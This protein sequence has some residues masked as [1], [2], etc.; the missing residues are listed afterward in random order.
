MPFEYELALDKS[1]FEFDVSVS[2]ADNVYFFEVSIGAVLAIDD[3]SCVLT[4]LMMPNAEILYDRLAEMK[5]IEPRFLDYT[6]LLNANKP[7]G[8]RNLVYAYPVMFKDVDHI[9]IQIMYANF[10]LIWTVLHEVA[11]V[12]LGHFQLLDEESRKFSDKIHKNLILRNFECDF[13]IDQEKINLCMELCADTYATSKFFST[14][15]RS[16]AIRFSLPKMVRS[17]LSALSFLMYSS[18]IYCLLL[19]RRQSSFSTYGRQFVGQY[20]APRIRMF[21]IMA[22][23]VPSIDNNKKI[24]APFYDVLGEPDNT[25]TL[26]TEEFWKVFSGCLGYFDK[27]LIAVQ[28]VPILP[29]ELDF[30][31]DL[32]SSAPA[33]LRYRQVRDELYYKSLSQIAAAVTL[34]CSGNPDFSEDV[35]FA[36]TYEEWRQLVKACDSIWPAPDS[37]DIYNYGWILSYQDIQIPLTTAFFNEVE[38]NAPEFAQLLK[39]DFR[40]VAAK[41]EA[42]TKE[43]ILR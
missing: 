36:K 21:N 40:V 8:A 6:D 26:Y 39:H 25:E 34:S 4:K 7:G 3:A 33:E 38:N 30:V 22:C 23:M 37:N 14:F 2:K 17:K 10:A 16:D 18:S 5:Y 13:P 1:N 9:E 32:S 43:R 24:L 42:F 15:F 35:E 20:P 19:H 27:F 28:A 29:W 31:F 11:H 41:I 12:Q